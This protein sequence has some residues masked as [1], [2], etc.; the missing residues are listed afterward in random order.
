MQILTKLWQL[1][2]WILLG[3]AAIALFLNRNQRLALHG[4]VRLIAAVL[5]T[6]AATALVWHLLT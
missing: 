6:G 1:S 5:L 3:M 2:A 4:Y